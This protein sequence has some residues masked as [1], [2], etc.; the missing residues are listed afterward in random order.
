[1]THRERVTWF[2]HGRAA[3]VLL[4]FEEGVR[5]L[6]AVEVGV[7]KDAVL[8]SLLIGVGARSQPDAPTTPT[9]AVSLVVARLSA[10]GCHDPGA[11]GAP[12]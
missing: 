7:E 10:Y 11:G 8:A 5:L 12:P 6:G 1:M 3:D 2:A 4:D 9:M